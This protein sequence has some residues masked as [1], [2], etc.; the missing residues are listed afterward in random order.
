LKRFGILTIQFYWLLLT[1]NI[2]FTIVASVLMGVSGIKINA[3]SFLIA[4]LMG[5][6]CAIGL[7][8]FNSQ[9]E[10][11]YFRNTG[12]GMRRIILSAL[13]TDGLIYLILAT[14]STLI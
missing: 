2:A 9:N 5:F 4:K 7:H 12:Y 13:V 14:L 1:Y 8:Y 3:A 11:F 6:A 10:Y